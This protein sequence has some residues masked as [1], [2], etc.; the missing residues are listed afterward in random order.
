MDN[1]LA[2][3]RKVIEEDLVGAE[4]FRESAEELSKSITLE[5][6]QARLR[7]AEMISKS[8][9]KIKQNRQKGMLEATEITNTMIKDSNDAIKKM[10]KDADKKI[11]KISAELVP[12]IITKLS[13][14]V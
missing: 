11:D 7:A 4:K 5:V 8:K 10:K 1:I 14:K 12:E 3:R 13:S 6:D 2:N 9:D